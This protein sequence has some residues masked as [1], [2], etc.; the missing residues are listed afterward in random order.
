MDAGSWI[1]IILLI[2]LLMG[3]FYFSGVETAFSSV[4]KVRI[5]GYAEDG[6]KKAAKALYIVDHLIAPLLH[7]SLETILSIPERRPLSRQ[8]S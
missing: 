3:S 2:V 1:R 4:N 8:L 5:R 6:N 7:P